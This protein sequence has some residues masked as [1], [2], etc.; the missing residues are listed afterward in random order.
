[1]RKSR[2]HAP[3]HLWSI[4]IVFIFLY[5][6]GVY[7]YFMVLEPNLDYYESQGFGQ[8]HLDYFTNYPPIPKVFWTAGVFSGLMAPVLLLFRSRWSIFLSLISAASQLILAVVTFGLMRRWDVYGPW[9]SLF[10]MAIVALTFGMYLYCRLMH[11]RG[12]LR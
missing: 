3:W 4:A 6:Q 5:S 7:D 12:V 8:E 2:I 9:I 11:S 1:M 10:D